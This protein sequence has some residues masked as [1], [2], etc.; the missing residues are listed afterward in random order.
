[1]GQIWAAKFNEVVIYKVRIL[2]VCIEDKRIKFSYSIIDTIII[3]SDN[4]NTG[5][6]NPITQ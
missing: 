1:M 5:N 4:N 6:D 3:D 2:I